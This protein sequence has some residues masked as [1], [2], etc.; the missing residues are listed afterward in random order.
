M[1]RDRTTEDIRQE[2]ISYI[3]IQF[4]QGWLLKFQV[5]LSVTGV[6]KI[7]HLGRRMDLFRSGSWS[8]GLAGEILQ[9]RNI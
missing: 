3:S 8:E 6:D 5:R 7:F 9:F 4:H 2:R 1:K